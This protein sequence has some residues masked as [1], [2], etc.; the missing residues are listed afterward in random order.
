[1]LTFDLVESM[2]AMITCQLLGNSSVC[3]ANQHGGYLRMRGLLLAQGTAR[4]ARINT[5]LREAAP[6][7]G[8]TVAQFKQSIP[9]NLGLCS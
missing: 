4:H 8:E 3:T 1:M 6:M 2:Y 9:S 7:R 5:D